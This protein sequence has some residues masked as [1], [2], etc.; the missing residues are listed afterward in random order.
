[1]VV[2]LWPNRF[3]VDMT[4]VEYVIKKVENV[5]SAIIW[6]VVV[7]LSGN[8]AMPCLFLNGNLRF[9]QLDKD[10]KYVWLLQSD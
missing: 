9:F 2:A 5:K 7:K 10:W 1:M 6:I 8:K 4:P 3:L